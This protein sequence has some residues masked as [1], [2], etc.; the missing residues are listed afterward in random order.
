MCYRIKGD[1]I[2]LIVYWIFY[3]G[4]VCGGLYYF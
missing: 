1:W 4:G 3:G 2:V